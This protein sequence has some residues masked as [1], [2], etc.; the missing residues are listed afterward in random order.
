MAG[1][2]FGS[3]SAAMKSGQKCMTSF[4]LKQKWNRKQMKIRND[5]Y[6]NFDFSFLYF[7]FAFLGKKKGEGNVLC[8]F[9]Y[10]VFL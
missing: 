10:K 8:V 1:K 9:M 5:Y 2:S 3:V 4:D 6:I 7:F